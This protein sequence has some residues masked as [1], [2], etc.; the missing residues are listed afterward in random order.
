MD[1]NGRRKMPQNAFH[2]VHRNAP[3]PEKTKDMVD[4]EPI[5]I[6]AHLSKTSLPPLIAVFAHLFPVIGR[7]TPILPFDRKIVRWRPRLQVHMIKLGLHP[8]IAAVAKN[9]D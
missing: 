7:E 9:A 4:P 1:G 5:K 2:N 3:D 8:G 6:V